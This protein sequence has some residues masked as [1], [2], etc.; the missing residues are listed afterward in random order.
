MHHQ[1][2]TT[3]NHRQ[4]HLVEDWS[5]LQAEKHCSDFA[6]LQSCKEI[7]PSQHRFLLFCPGFQLKQILLWGAAF[8]K[9]FFNFQPKQ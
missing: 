5:F 1:Q 8:Y 7:Q 4:F 9:A 2:Q 3:D 6:P